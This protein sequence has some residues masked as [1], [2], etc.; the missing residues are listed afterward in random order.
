MAWSIIVGPLC[1]TFV[2]ILVR[3]RRDELTEEAK[4]LRRNATRVGSHT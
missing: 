1:R 3:S 2:H 4:R